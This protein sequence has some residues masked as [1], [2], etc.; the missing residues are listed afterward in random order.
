MSDAIAEVQVEDFMKITLD[1]LPHKEIETILSAIGGGG[2]DGAIY[3]FELLKLAGWSGNKLTS[4]AKDP[5]N[6]ASA[7]NKIRLLLLKT[8][9]S[10][11]LRSL[12]ES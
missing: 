10:K 7:F 11:E 9:D 12:L 2:A 3:K 6:A 8:N 1:P 5:E 4:F